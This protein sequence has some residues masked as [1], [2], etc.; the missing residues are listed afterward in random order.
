[1]AHRMIG[2]TA[3]NGRRVVVLSCLFVLVA[4]CTAGP[5]QRPPVAVR[6]ENLPAVS[7]GPAPPVTPEVLPP[8]PPQNPSLTFVDC[9][10][11]LLAVLGLPADRDLSVECGELPVPADPTRPGL[12]SVLLGVVR[13]GTGGVSSEKAPLL[14]LGDSVAGP[15]VGHAVELAARASPELLDRFTVIGLDRRGAG[16]DRLDCAP[17]EAR[18]ALIDADPA[19]ITDADLAA[20]LT[21]A[22]SIVQTCNL[23]PQSALSGFGAAATA[24]DVELL[25]SRLGVATLSAVGVGDGAVALSEWARSV[26]GGVGRLVLD[27]PGDPL[28][29]ETEEAAA[30]AA[31]TEAAFDA[32]ALACTAPGTCPLG[33]DPRAAV[34]GLLDGLR[35]QPLAA[36]DGRR[37]TAGGANRALLLGLLDPADW[38]AVSAALTA[39]I[40]GDAVPLLDV[41]DPVTGPRGR[42]DGTLAVACNDAASRLSPIEVGELATRLGSEHPLAGGVLALDLLAC[43]P[44]P[45]GTAPP[46]PAPSDELP[47][48]LVI[49]TAADPRAGLDASRRTA[50]SLAS[51]RFLDWQ[52]AGTGAYP[53]TPCVTDVVEGLLVDD[54]IPPPATLC[55]P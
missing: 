54:R 22:G 36:P 11:D 27:G 40:D 23:D 1:M 9:T 14:A 18:A 44:W 20:L 39:A 47:P 55:P 25:R 43:A 34:T 31:S 45:V 19:A 16:V 24:V 37:L 6:G 2:K 12:G 17:A 48:V 41:L 42:F 7:A 50:R 30:R 51:G 26:P 29:T 32:F 52:G 13:V 10:A 53:R 15:T 3:K 49:G 35:A 5:S 46:P 28:A 21:Q 38:T 8:L 4:G 33:I